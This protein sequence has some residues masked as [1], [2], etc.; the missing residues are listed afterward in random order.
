MYVYNAYVL[1]GVN[2]LTPD[3]PKEDIDKASEYMTK[4]YPSLRQ[5]FPL[6]NFKTMTK[7]HKS[8]I[9]KALVDM[10]NQAFSGDYE[11]DHCIA[12]DILCEL[13]KAL[14]AE[15]VVTEYEK[16]RRCYA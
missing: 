2:I 8:A 5:L 14:G 9:D 10:R 16:V 15:E 12:D 6:D 3:S 11:R 1:K 7:K 4:Q 13:L